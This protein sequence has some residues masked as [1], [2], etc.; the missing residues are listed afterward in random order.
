[1]ERLAGLPASN[2][3]NNEFEVLEIDNI[4]VREEQLDFLKGIKKFL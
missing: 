4:K 3:K 2:N 1:M